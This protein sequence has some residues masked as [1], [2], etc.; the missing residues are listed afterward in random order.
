MTGAV[1]SEGRIMPVGAVPLKVEAANEAR[2][3]RVLVPDEVDTADA[4][5]ATPFL[6]QVSPVGS[7]SQAYEA[8]TDRPLRP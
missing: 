6:V 1:G 7:I 4:D 8:L 2:M 3:H 5:W